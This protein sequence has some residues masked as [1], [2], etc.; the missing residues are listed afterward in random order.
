[1]PVGSNSNYPKQYGIYLPDSLTSNLEIFKLI[2]PSTANSLS[3]FIS[4]DFSICSCDPETSII[5]FNTEQI[6]YNKTYS[7]SIYWRDPA[8]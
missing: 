3:A 5:N 1:V 7:I 8:I 2:P 6:E 4:T